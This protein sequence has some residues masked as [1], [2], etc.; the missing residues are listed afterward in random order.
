LVEETNRYYRQYLDTLDEEWSPLP[1]V[2]V[3]EMCLFA[4]IVVQ[5]GHNQR[6][7]LKDYWLPHG[8]YF[9]AFYGN[10]MK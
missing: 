10:T 2:T 7:K 9:T 6:G 8:E 5:M 3:Q 1:E 4:A